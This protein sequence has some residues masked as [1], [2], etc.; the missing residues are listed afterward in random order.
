MKKLLCGVLCV[1][2]AICFFGCKSKTEELSD[3]YNILELTE[4]EKNVNESLEFKI[5]DE[6]GTVWIEREH[7]TRVLVSF[8]KSRNRYLELKLNE[9]GIK[10][11]KKALKGNRTLTIMVNDEPLLSYD[12]VEATNVQLDDLEERS[13]I[14]LGEYKDV[15]SWFNIL[16]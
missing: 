14:V 16:T 3:Q 9:D 4:E 5:V 6:D 11:L 7:V 8:E 12:G 1:L 13:A 15:I 10:K 2:M